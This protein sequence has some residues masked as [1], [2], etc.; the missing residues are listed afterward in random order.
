V[1]EPFG[2]GRAAGRVPYGH[3][4]SP[5][6][7]SIAAPSGNNPTL[8]RGWMGRK[9]E[10]SHCTACAQ[11]SARAGGKGAHKNMIRFILPHFNPE[12]ACNSPLPTGVRQAETPLIDCFPG[13][14]SWRVPNFVSDP[15][16][17]CFGVG[18]RCVTE[19]GGAA[20]AADLSWMAHG[21]AMDL[22]QLP[23]GCVF[24]LTK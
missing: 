8:R 23:S 3:G 20:G 1:K 12:L 19:P 4:P 18:F 10:L 22:R 7:P 13:G 24:P 21:G 15:S 14:I 9:A 11:S 5:G 16:G 17:L 2:D 6:T